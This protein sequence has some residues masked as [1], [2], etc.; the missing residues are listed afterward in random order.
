MG[1]RD[2]YLIEEYN[3]KSTKVIKDKKEANGLP[4]DYNDD[5]ARKPNI[6]FCLLDNFK[7]KNDA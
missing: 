2:D 7:S 4:I 6:N 1:G 5:I 3:L